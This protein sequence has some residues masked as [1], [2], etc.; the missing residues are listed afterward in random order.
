MRHVHA[1]LGVTLIGFAAV[2]YNDPDWYYWAP[3]YLLA[4]IWSL[5]AWWS[6]HVLNQAPARVGGWLSI[7]LF[8]AGFASLASTIGRNWIHVEE[9]R[10][11]FGYLICAASTA[12][13]LWE[14]RQRGG[15][16]AKE[17]RT[18]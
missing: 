1:A 9:A 17:R 8:L 18:A 13:A 14:S 4:V 2:Q 15:A 7:V 3:V 10:E 16:Q 12:F 11:A 6:P 5:S